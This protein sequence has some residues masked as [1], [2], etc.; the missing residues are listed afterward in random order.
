[1][2]ML[3]VSLYKGDSG[4]FDE[5]TVAICRADN[6]KVGFA[7]VSKS[8]LRG[9]EAELPGPV[10]DALHWVEVLTQH[11]NFHRSNVLTMI[12]EYPSGEAVLDDDAE[13][14]RPTKENIMEASGNAV[15]L[16]LDWLV[17]DVAPG[18]IIFFIFSGHGVPL[19]DGMLI[20]GED[21][22]LMYRYQLCGFGL[23]DS[24]L[25]S[26]DGHS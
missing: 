6:D 19:P 8:Y 21:E 11:C 10:N 16:A 1:L 26:S 15:D 12:D 4:F 13:Y 3:E 5:F 18:D 24:V 20:N 22:S 14:M 9:T 25:P 2:V 7:N 23:G 17:E